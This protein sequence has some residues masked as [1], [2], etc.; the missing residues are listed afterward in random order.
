MAVVDQVVHGRLGQT[1]ICIR[2]HVNHLV[3]T[4]VVGDQAHVVVHED[5]FYLFIGTCNQGLFFFGHHN[6]S[7]G[8]GQTTAE[9]VGVS[10]VLHI[11]QEL[12]RSRHVR[13]AQDVGNDVPQGLLRQQF[14][15][16]SNL[17]RNH[18]VE[19]D[20]SYRGLNQFDNILAVL[21]GAGTNLHNGVQV[22][23]LFVVGNHYL[24]RRIEHLAFALDGVLGGVLTGLGHVVQTQD[25]VLRRYRD[26]R[27]VGRVQDVVRRQHQDLRFQ[28][29]GRSQRQVNRH[30]V[31]VKVGVESRTGQGVQLNG[32][33]LNQF[34]LERLD[35]QAV[36]RRSPVQQDRM[37]LHDVLQDVPNY[38]LALVNDFLSRLNRFHDSALDQLANNKRLEQFSRHVLGKTAFVQLQFRS[39]ND[40]RT[41]RVVYPLTQKVLAETT[42]LAFQAVGQRLQCA[43]ALCLNSAGLAGVVKQ[44]VYRL[45]QH[46]LFVA[47]NHFGSLDFQQ[48][49]QTVVADNHAAVQIVQ[50]GRSKTATVQ[51]H[52]WTQFGRNN[53]NDLHD[54]PFGVVFHPLVCLAQIFNYL[55][56]LEGFLL[57]LL[58]GFVVGA[59]AQVV[60]QLGQ[61]QTLKQHQQ[62]IGTHLGDELIGV[63]I[64]Q[65]VVVLVRQAVQGIQVLFFGEELQHL[66]RTAFGIHGLTGLDNDVPLV[67]NDHV[68]LLAGKPQQIANFV[69]Q[70]TEVP[71][72]RNRHH[73]RDVANAL[74]TYLLLRY[75]YP[76]PVANNPFVSD[77]LVL[78]ASTLKI[79]N[80]TKDSLAKQAIAFGLVR[81]VVDGFRL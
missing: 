77:A 19:Q 18:I 45:L 43:V 78:S 30:L 9:G 7:Q 37:A 62:R 11:V 66:Q 74:A 35:T 20:A 61:V 39:N 68:Q 67:V 75:F 69:G 54:H 33:S 71:N 53:R 22:D 48:T 27:T 46:A 25:H 29:G 13:A 42:L 10:Q 76:T 3:V 16:K 6:V 5:V 81:T 24:L 1:R 36:Q 41:R 65:V 50:V 55:Q 70:G 63:G 34:G 2:P 56:T 26:R 31:A 4:L 64:V 73:Q 23:G 40:N 60:R 44:A 58:A 51:R 52:Q 17:D 15:D 49:L 38:R 72:V 14:V 28:N 32:L 12:G 21:Q 47:Q 80:R 8:E 57:A 79:L 59:V